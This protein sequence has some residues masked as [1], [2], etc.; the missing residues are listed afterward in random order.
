MK[1]NEYKLVA[2]T[3]QGDLYIFAYDRECK[4]SIEG[5]HEGAILTLA[6]GANN[7]FIISG[8]MDKCIKIW[9]QALQAIAHHKFDQNPLESPVNAA[10]ASIDYK[11][12]GNNIVV[13]VGTYGGEIME[14]AAKESEHSSKQEAKDRD[15][16]N[17]DLMSACEVSVLVHSHYSGELWGVAPCPTD[18]NV[19]ATGGD[20][21]TVRLWSISEKRMFACESTGRPVRCVGWSPDGRLLAVGFHESVK[22]GGKV[23][24]ASKSTSVTSKGI[25]KS[26]GKATAKTKKGG[27]K[28]ASGNGGTVSSQDDADTNAENASCFV[29]LV[30]GNTLERVGFGGS[31]TAWISDIKFSPKG[32]MLAMGSH[33]K[34][35][36]VYNVPAD[37]ESED[38]WREAFRYNKYIFN[39][40]SSAITH[41]DFSEDEQ[42]F[43]TNCQAYELLFGEAATGKQKTS[44]T[45]LRNYNAPVNGDSEEYWSTWTCT[46]GWPVQSIWAEG[47][48]GSDINAVDRSLVNSLVVTADDFGLV[49]LFRYPCIDDGA[50]CNAYTGHSSHVTNVRWTKGDHLLSVGGNDK[51]IFVWK[52]TM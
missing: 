52:L 19:V 31:S 47:A 15:G 36:Y 1:G 28:G 20:D 29:Y 4:N 18:P 26:T 5:A 32:T 13:L 23:K 37:V 43:Q 24:A 35:L 48:D 33:D 50:K 49:K 9:N 2:G 12:V 16:I 46:L 17:F 8:G 30:D 11:V 25:G 38:A 6:E 44:A 21:G 41:F 45:E 39:K 42:Y 40:H 34:R 10:V 51:C 14:V 7:E 22:G 27:K 3:S